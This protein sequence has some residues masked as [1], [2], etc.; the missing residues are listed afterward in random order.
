MQAIK[1]IMIFLFSLNIVFA[2]NMFEDE[3][4][5]KLPTIKFTNI[6]GKTYNI[7]NYKNVKI[8]AGENVIGNELL[9]EISLNSDNTSIVYIRSD[10][11]TY[12]S[13]NMRN[14]LSLNPENKNIDKEKSISENYLSI[15]NISISP[16]PANNK[17]LISFEITEKSNVT[18]SLVN[19]I[20]QDET[21][22]MENYSIEGK[23]QNNFDISSFERGNYFVIFK[24]N[25]HQVAKILNKFGN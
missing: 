14:W 22:V 23:F 4:F 11:T 5:E 12:R 9:D 21:F 24:L 20:S 25:G 7:I 8:L 15:K 2:E 18:I 10:G 13:N 16:N 19:S 3:V 6:M 1:F 17:L